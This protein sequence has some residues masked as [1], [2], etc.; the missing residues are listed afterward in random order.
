MEKL[1]KRKKWHQAKAGT[2]SSP[3]GPNC[4]KS[5]C[6][7]QAFS[8]PIP[9]LWAA[10]P[11]R[12]WCQN[13]RCC[14]E[15]SC[16]LPQQPRPPGAMPIYLL[17]LGPSRYIQQLSR[18]LSLWH[19]GEGISQPIV[20]SFKDKCTTH[21]F[22]LGK[23]SPQLC[24]H[25]FLTTG[26]LLINH[27]CCLFLYFKGLFFPLRR[28]FFLTW[29]YFIT[30]RQNIKFCGCVL[31]PWRNSRFIESKK[32]ATLASFNYFGHNFVFHCSGHCSTLGHKGS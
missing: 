3:T 26:L 31:G 32:G 30:S 4:E 16:V 15:Q 1:L 7:T 20:S 29:A 11:P 21:S 10:R 27:F 28:T 5:N 18:P 12:A 9:N 2:S 25:Y 23:S 8:A 13:P 22:S 24:Q 19:L 6:P 14:R 17:L